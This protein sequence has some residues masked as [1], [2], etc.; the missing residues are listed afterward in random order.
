MRDTGLTEIY[1]DADGVKHATAKLKSSAQVE[2][3]LFTLSRATEK[4]SCTSVLPPKYSRM[5]T[6][7]S[8]RFHDITQQGYGK[9]GTR[10]KVFAQALPH[11]D[12]KIDSTP[13]T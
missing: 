4:N 12:S 7:G 2:G 5:G 11:G 8:V 10:A 6:A 3:Q 1:L 9:R 13:A